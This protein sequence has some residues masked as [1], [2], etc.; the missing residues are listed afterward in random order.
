VPRE[1]NRI[2]TLVEDL[3]ELAR[4][5]KYQ[6]SATQVMTLLHQTIDFVGEE[7][8]LHGIDYQLNAVNGLP[9]VWADPNQ[10]VKAFL[11]L[12]RNAIHAMPHGGHLTIEASK[13]ERETSTGPSP[14]SDIVVLIQDTGTGMAP[15]T[16]KAV[17]NPFFTTKDKGTGL[18]LAITHK[19]ITEHAGRIEV[20]SKLDEGTCFTIHLPVPKSQ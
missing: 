4:T 7:L 10:L 8:Q 5:P 2:N 12:I 13:K 9:P 19:V 18:G 15:E 16:M 3:L 11:N 14:G 17:F 1:L 6:F 20:N